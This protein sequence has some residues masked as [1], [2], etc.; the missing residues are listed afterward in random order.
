MEINEIIFAMSAGSFESRDM[1]AVVEWSIAC[2]STGLLLPYIVG[3]AKEERPYFD[4]L[5]ARC[6]L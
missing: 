5:P 4:A 1:H 3:L 2:A 6:P